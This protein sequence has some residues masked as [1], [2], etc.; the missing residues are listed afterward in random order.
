[1]RNLRQYPIT[2]KEIEE[3]L[4]READELAKGEIQYGDMRPLLFH[5]AAKII[6]RLDFATHNIGMGM[7]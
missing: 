5:T 4:R 1:M 2:L 3:A 6:H 7:P